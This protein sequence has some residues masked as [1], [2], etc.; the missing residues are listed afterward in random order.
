M[1]WSNIRNNR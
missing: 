1:Y